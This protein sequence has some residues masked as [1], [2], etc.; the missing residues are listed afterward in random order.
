MVPPVNPPSTTTQKVLKL[1]PSDLKVEVIKANKIE[2]PYSI[3]F[4]GK[5]YLIVPNEINYDY[6]SPGMINAL[7]GLSTSGTL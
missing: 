6:N 3:T 2:E 1:I 4:N 7:L 5:K